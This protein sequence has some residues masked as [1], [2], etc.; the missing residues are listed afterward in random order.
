MGMDTGS[1]GASRLQERPKNGNA[2]LA[3]REDSGTEEKG[4]S[5]LTQRGLMRFLADFHIHS[6]FSRATSKDLTLLELHTSALRKGVSLLGTGDFTHPGWRSEIEDHLVPAEDGLF[7]L[8]GDLERC[9]SQDLPPSCSSGTV[10]FILSTEISSIYKKAGRVRKVHNLVLVPDFE[11]ADRLSARLERLGTLSSD[12]RPILGLDCRL[13][14]EL[15]LELSPRSLFV[16]AHIWTPWF[17]V[18]G[19]L[20]GFDSIEECFEDLTPEIFALETG[21]SSDPGMN[22]R[23]SALDRFSLVSNSDAHSAEK[24]GREANLF[25]CDLSFDSIREALKNPGAAGFL[26]TVEFFPEQGK[27]HLDGHRKCGKRMEPKETLRTK[28]LCPVCGKK[29]T[30]GV[31]HRV[32]ALSDRPEGARPAGALPYERLVS[33]AE[34]VGEALGQGPQTKKVR[35]YCERLTAHL[36]PELFVLRECPLEEID[37][38][39][40]PLVAE[41]VRRV[42]S[43]EL[44]VEAGF[45]GQFG[46]IRIFEPDER[47]RLEGH[48][49]LI[50]PDQ[51]EE[52]APR[53]PGGRA[54]EGR[55]E[56]PPEQSQAC[57]F[58][59]QVS[60]GHTPA[61]ATRRPL[62]V[63]SLEFFERLDP[64]QQE[65]IRT[66]GR[67][68]V[69]KAGP[70][71]GKTLT[72]TCRI[73]FQIREQGMDPGRILAVTFTNRAARE[74]EE[75]LGVLLECA[76]GAR[77]LTIRTFHSLGAD[78]LRQGASLLRMPDDFS[79][80][81][82]TGQ[83]LVLRNAVPGLSK[84]EADHILER[85]SREKSSLR[86][87]G[88]HDSHAGA[89]HEFLEAYRRYQEALE[90]R[91]ALDFDDLVGRAVLLLCSDTKFLRATVDRFRAIS[92][93]EYQDINDAQYR[94]LRLLAP[95]SPDLCVIGDPDQSIYGFRGA[96]PAYFS[97]FKID[98]PGAREIRLLRNYRSTAA[99]LRGA[100]AVVSATGGTEDS[101]PAAGTSR[102]RTAEGIHNEHNESGGPGPL[103]A[104]GDPCAEGPRIRCHAA[105]SERAE[106]IFVAETIERLMGGT[107]HVSMYAGKV[108]AGEGPVCSS[109][110]DIGV[111]FR[112]SAQA[113]VLEQALERQGIPYQRAGK[114]EMLRTK[115]PRAL[116]AALRLL[117]RP[118]DRTALEQLEEYSPRGRRDLLA[119][120]SGLRPALAAGTAGLAEI[121]A[122]LAELL[123]PPSEGPGGRD[124]AS[125][126]LIR[127]AAAYGADVERFL[128]DVVLE[129]DEDWIDASA[130]R[131]TLSTLHAAKGLEFPVVF[132]VGCEAHLLPCRVGR[133]RSDP[134]EER[135]LLY[136][137]MTRACRLL[138]I[139][140]A[141]TRFLLG[142]RIQGS[143][144]PFLDD[145]PEGVIETIDRFRPKETEGKRR[146]RDRQLTLF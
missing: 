104:A 103:I 107:E 118:D 33:L 96:E 14:L 17:S 13:L 145:I 73:A 116:I 89:D 113:P 98:Y 1:R 15:L 60:S 36:G 44:T 135:R 25:D 41:A 92:V 38:H 109:F 143:P 22:W 111:L 102:G 94:L 139:T 2:T 54:A 48:L 100:S 142:E 128:A 110:S 108:A 21:L 40:G 27:Y 106:A 5:V 53:C 55:H 23:L 146:P 130:E 56:A 117:R 16:P 137:G 34:T 9:A 63:W 134:A 132:L 29:V 91:C 85:I 141:K 62:S 12:G 75:R 46:S 127:R 67:P 93:D 95:G 80:L 7:R 10:R 126:A 77:S 52:E 30:V 125:G 50:G 65:A 78:L 70:G 82:R 83:E 138:Y 47:K 32:E 8:R 131:V 81:D 37:T 51:E 35:E 24:I 79:I 99:I 57:R 140:W 133:H 123:I 42:R 11:T 66:V 74:M 86:Y 26:G 97:R 90:E 112:L 114:R 115:G 64:E 49:A 45:D 120:I 28:G 121:I 129:R 84:D 124:D 72:L 19:S 20:S 59:G 136:V 76:D 58:D 69:I 39:A 119:R 101:A 3:P 4:V 71:T 31:M 144:S 6:R 87:P 43:G 88:D 122:R 68:L 105:R 18:L 61:Q